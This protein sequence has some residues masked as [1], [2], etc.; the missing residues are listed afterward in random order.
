[1]EAT[2]DYLFKI[3][4][5][6]D[7]GVGKTSLMRRYTDNTY[8]KDGASTIGVDFKIKTVVVSGR[9]VKLQ[10]W[11]TA[12]QE[13]FKAIVAHYYRGANGIMLVFDMLNSETFEH[14]KDW[15]AEL[16]RRDVPQTTPIK[17][18][19]NKIDARSA[20]QVSKA[21]IKAFLDTYNL[22]ESCFCEVSAQDGINIE[23]C[24]T[25]FTK[26]LIEVA[27]SPTNK[28]ASKLA[29]KARNDAKNSRRCC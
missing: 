20:V 11:D 19:G 26:C 14:L 1:M 4:L 2:H 13:R 15:M 22:P 27:G 21:S 5:I 10:I 6:G 29:F 3:I 7:S 25:S 16:G 28:V 24:F 12:G 9:R 17:I 8:T 23:E 18:I